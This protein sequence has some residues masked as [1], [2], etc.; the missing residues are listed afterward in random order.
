MRA[1]VRFAAWV[2]AGTAFCLATAPNFLNLLGQSLG[3]TF[4]SIFPAVPFAAL[5]T[6]IFALRWKE[7]RGL[8][9][10]EGGPVSELRVRGLG[11]GILAVLWLSEPLT[12]KTVVTAGI[13]VIFTIYA[14]SL[15]VNPL[16]KGLLLPYAG[17]YTVGLGAPFALQWAFGEPL[18]YA[19]TA[20]ASRFVGIIG[21][22]VVWQGTQFQLFSRTGDVVNG[23]VAPGCSSIISITTF[24]GL[25][26]LMH[27]D[28]KKDLRSTAVVAVAGVA[29][30][31][32]LN[33]LRIL[34]LMWVGYVD[35]A[36][37][38][39]GVHNWIGYA[40]FLGFYLAALTVYSKIGRSGVAGYSISGTSYR[41]P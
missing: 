10:A 1:A 7:L 14:A 5:L 3:D 23:F 26:A 40:M 37:T 25:L 11:A 19:S 13:S 17:I 31:T 6:L 36:S 34:L 35:G 33:S 20:L 4:G 39:W 8:L 30:L 41:P 29:V 15:I 18:A 24:V 12:G 28:M 2:G 22:P 27:L 38:F 9:E 21:L 16:T 32:L